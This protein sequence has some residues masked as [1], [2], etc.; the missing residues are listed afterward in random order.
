MGA[1]VLILNK[2]DKETIE[3]IE[4]ECYNFASKSFAIILIFLLLL[5]VFNLISSDVF[6]GVYF[7]TI[8]TLVFFKINVRLIENDW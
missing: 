1:I 5:F 6:L 4:K 3:T 7:G 8:E 2:G